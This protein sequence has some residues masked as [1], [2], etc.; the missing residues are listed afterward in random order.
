[1]SLNECC[2]VDY[3]LIIAVIINE[4]LTTYNQVLNVNL[5]Y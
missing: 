4:N 1:M 3:L 5:D 2:K